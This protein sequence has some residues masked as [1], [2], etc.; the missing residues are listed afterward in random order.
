[1]TNLKPLIL[2][3][4]GSL[5]SSMPA[6]AALVAY[7]SFDDEFTDGSGNNN[8]LSVA[9][10]TPLITKV[11]GEHRFGGGAL[12]VASTTLDQAYLN[13]ATPLSFGAGDAWSVAFWARHR[14]GNDGRTGMIVGD[15]TSSNFI[16]IPRDGAVDGLRFRNSSAVNADYDTPPAGV[17]PA[18]EY[19][20]FAVIADG[21]GSVELFYDN[22]SLGTRSLATSFTIT[23][24]AQAFNQ[25]TQSMNG[26]IDELY[27]FDEAISADAVNAL[28]TGIPEP[29][30]GGIA[31]LGGLILLMRRRRGRDQLVQGS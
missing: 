21:L 6:G 4:C 1:M 12:D 25:T 24:V 27:I 14:P 30:V 19:H 26:Q 15:L 22:A 29:S 10:G 18:G 3:A 16:W 8:H 28:Y 9:A 2:L 23:S 7:Y 11:D 17:E 13:L 31:S 20:H 5:L